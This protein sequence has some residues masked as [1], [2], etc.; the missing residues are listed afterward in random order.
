MLGDFCLT[1]H[2]S[3]RIIYFWVRP[4]K[5]RKIFYLVAA[6]LPVVVRVLALRL[7]IRTNITTVN[8]NK[9]RAPDKTSKKGAVLRTSSLSQRLRI[10]NLLVKGFPTFDVSSLSCLL[11]LDAKQSQSLLNRHTGY[12]SRDVESQSTLLNR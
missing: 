2:I 3:A 11:L 6:S 10:N 9:I 4:E 5:T 1:A 7:W 8:F 12:T